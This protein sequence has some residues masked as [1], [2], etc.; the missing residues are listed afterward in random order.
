MPFQSFTP[1]VK[2]FSGEEIEPAKGYKALSLLE[3]PL[4]TASWTVT[5]IE[6]GVELE[7]KLR[8]FVSNKPAYEQLGEAI[9][10]AEG[11]KS[12]LQS[13]YSNLVGIVELIEKNE[14]G[15]FSALFAA[16]ADREAC[17][18]A[19]ASATAE[20]SKLKRERSEFGLDAAKET[21]QRSDFPLLL[22]ARLVFQNEVIWTHSLETQRML[23]KLDGRFY[24]EGQAGD[25]S[26]V[27]GLYL[28]RSEGRYDIAAQLLPAQPLRF[29]LELVGPVKPEAP[30]LEGP[31]ITI[32]ATLN[33]STL[34]IEYEPQPAPAIN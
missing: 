32:G 3:G 18:S 1:I 23:Q 15:N 16:R 11:A 28:E 13:Q 24:A 34:A 8:Q 29:E 5:G 12:R 30:D 4:I 19:I 31:E 26:G 33:A 17:Q 14:P 27:E 21:L 25:Y 22:I 20:V 7:Y 2:T 9:T 10:E 6:I